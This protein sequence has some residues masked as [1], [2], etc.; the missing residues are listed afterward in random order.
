[1]RTIN[2]S[3]EIITEPNAARRV[4]LA[5]RVCYKSEGRIT[6]DSALP[7]VRRLIEMGHL[8][9]LE[10]GRVTIK[11]PAMMDRIG[12]SLDVYGLSNRF[13]CHGN[14]GYSLNLRDGLALGYSLDHLLKNP[15]C[16]DDYLTVRFI[17]DRAI[18]NELVRHRVFSFSQ[19]STRYVRY[20]GIKFVMPVGGSTIKAGKRMRMDAW[21]DAMERA[22]KAY[23]AMLKA[24]ASPQMARSVLPLSTKTELIMSGLYA[25]W[26]DMFSIRTAKAAHPQM[27][28][29]MQI[30]IDL[31]EFPRNKITVGKA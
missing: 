13:T 14:G 2:Q 28:A 31:D 17:T 26:E 9:P 18:A 22:E 20:R 3:A 19:E 11:E 6:K 21:L 1:M 8:S 12:S 15:Q 25:H 30:L 24:G 10:H 23:R 16:S 5:A 4:E 27:R 7:F 29:L